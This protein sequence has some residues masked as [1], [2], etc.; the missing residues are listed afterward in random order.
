MWEN[1]IT[2][3]PEEVTFTPE[4]RLDNALS[5][6]PAEDKMLD[7]LLRTYGW[8]DWKRIDASSLLPGRSKSQIIVRAGMLIGSARLADFSGLKVS[9]KDVR[10]FVI[11]VKADQTPVRYNRPRDPDQMESDRRVAR[12]AL[13]PKQNVCRNLKPF[14]LGT[15]DFATRRLDLQQLKDYFD[16]LKLLISD[17]EVLLAEKLGSEGAKFNTKI[18]IYNPEEEAFEPVHGTLDSGASVSCASAVL[19]LAGNK[20]LTS[21]DVKLPILTDVNNR[22]TQ[23]IGYAD[24]DVRVSIFGL[25]SKVVLTKV[26]MYF[27]N[28]ATWSHFLIGAD[29]LSKYGL[30]PWQ[31]LREKIL[32]SEVGN[33]Q[34]G[35]EVVLK[36][37]DDTEEHLD[38]EDL[39]L[40]FDKLEDLRR[41][42][43]ERE[44]LIPEREALKKRLLQLEIYVFQEIEKLWNKGLRPAIGDEMIHSCPNV[45][46]YYLG[47]NDYKFKLPDLQQDII[48]YIDPPDSRV[49]QADL[50]KIEL[51]ELNLGYYDVIVADPPWI[52]NVR[53]PNRGVEVPYNQLPDEAIFKL[54][55]RQI[56]HVGLVFLWVTNAKLDKAIRWLEG[57]KYKIMEYLCWLKRSK[58]GKWHQSNGYLLRH[59]KE[60]C[61]VA[62]RRRPQFLLQRYTD[63]L[64]TVVG[65]QSSKP[66]EL[67]EMIETM[68]PNKNI[69]KCSEELQ[70]VVR[71]GLPSETNCCLH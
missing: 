45:E 44:K 9:I 32:R 46:C 16:T 30:N 54:D 49:V 29:A 60:I 17:R 12:E 52:V 61:L 43:V 40:Y 2:I 34:D 56:Q 53:N 48:S 50:T 37:E 70:T 15:D 7:A 41:L 22:G 3:W 31:A 1:L 59:S 10:E 5:W 11:K 67:Y 4:E 51:G 20:L 14:V 33:I 58:A 57:M 28:S 35:E 42:I 26:R 63:V 27:V 25:C 13:L 47:R 65:P 8:G 66:E 68:M 21:P 62:R 64:E 24:V 6:T 36:I 69:L 19:H 18:E 38:E 71:D 55:L 39:D 23:A